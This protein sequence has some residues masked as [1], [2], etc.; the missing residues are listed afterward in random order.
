MIT[1]T[2]AAKAHLREVTKDRPGF[3][4]LSVKPKGCAGHEFNL[5]LVPEPEK[6]DDQI[7]VDDLVLLFERRWTMFIL[8]THIDHYD[9]WMGRDFV[10]HNVNHEKCGCGKSFRSGSIE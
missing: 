9:G 6:D 2:D 8:G 5:I 1:L 10:F 7:I 4:K 3:I